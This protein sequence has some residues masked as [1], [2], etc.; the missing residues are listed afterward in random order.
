MPSN[1]NVERALKAVALQH[2]AFERFVLTELARLRGIL[3]TGATNKVDRLGDELGS[4]GAAHID[5]ARFAE[6][7]QGA[8]HDA[9]TRAR[10]SRSIEVL[11]EISRATLDDF[12]EE[13][14]EWRSASSVVTSVLGRWGRAF[15][16]V[17]AADLAR[18]DQ[19]DPAQHDALTQLFGFD[20]WNK[21]YR[22][23]APPLVAVVD[24]ATHV[25][26]LS[27]VLDGNQ[28]IVLVM[29]NGTTPAGLVRL[30][31]P[32]TLVLQT[33]DDRG[34]DRFSA[35]NGPAIAA[36]VHEDAACFLHDPSAGGAAWQRLSIW[37][38][39]TEHPR[40]TVAGLSP[41]QQREEILQ[42]EALAVQPTL[43]A[44]ALEAL[45]AGSGDAAERLAAWLLAQ[46]QVP[47][48]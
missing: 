30:I 26:D 1:P 16:A 48:G 45:G 21:A 40:R 44:G 11:T 41:S 36:M 33:S 4:L 5:L 7:A 47:T 39:A 38:H 2:A 24:D 22:H 27:D 42:L 37:K 43:P 46:S 28:H 15:G 13:I 23:H 6:L 17:V 3:A 20:R 10:I 8:N 14:P 12:V 35:Y 19:Y 25:A 9:A 32:H 18:V 29:Q 34:L 31:T